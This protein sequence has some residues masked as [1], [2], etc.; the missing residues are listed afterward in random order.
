M[1]P[2]DIIDRVLAERGPAGIRRPL[3]KDFLG[4]TLPTRIELAAIRA[5]WR[6]S[7]GVDLA[8]ELQADREV[9][10]FTDDPHTAWFAGFEVPNGEACAIPP[11]LSSG[12]AAGA[13]F[14]LFQERFKTAL[15]SAGAPRPFAY[16]L[17][18]ALDEMASNA[19]EHAG[20]PVPPVAAYEVRR[21]GWSFGVTDLGVGLLRTLGRNPKL[22]ADLGDD[23]AA[24]KSAVRDGVSCTGVPGRGTGFGNMFRALADRGCSIRL[25]TS[26]A[27][28]R[29]QGISPAAHQLTYLLAPERAGFHVQVE[30]GF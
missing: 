24:L 10:E 15:V 25:R 6:Q 23:V 16:G 4:A 7:R 5:H 18:G 27:T 29:W 2:I 13:P 28:A 8:A 12:W 19:V 1:N 21:D 3:R 9:W 30:G 22:S 17:A 14:G 11:R 26:G 20:A